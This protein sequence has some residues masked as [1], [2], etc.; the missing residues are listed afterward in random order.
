MLINIV[1]YQELIAINNLEN[2]IL[3]CIWWQNDIYILL[4]LKLKVFRRLKFC[5]INRQEEEEKEEE[6]A[7][8][9][10]TKHSFL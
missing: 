1:K 10:Y 5:C 3:K 8:H 6:A 9:Y 7:P 2:S 4:V